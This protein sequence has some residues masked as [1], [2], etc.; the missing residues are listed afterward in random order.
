MK[1]FYGGVPVNS[2]K[3]KHY[4]VSTNDATLKPS[5]MQAGVTAYAK[6]Q[7]VTGTGKSFEFANYGA[8]YTNVPLVVP[9]VIN[10]VEISSLNY[11]VQLSIA[12]SNMKNVDFSS[13]QTIG[14]IVID[15]TAYPITVVVSNGKMTI[16]CEK[17]LKL[18]IFY[19]KDNYT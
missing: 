15:G 9:T 2:M 5:D 19:G 1:M 16:S 4:E 14:S 18:E 11:P 8:V 12:L 7:K 17:T 6:G 3:V 13:I 10:I